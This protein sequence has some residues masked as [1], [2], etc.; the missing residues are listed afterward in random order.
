MDECI[1]SLGEAQIFT[2]LDCNSGYWQVEVD[3]P[4]RD[5]TK[6]TSHFGVYRFKCIPFGLRNT[7]AR[8]Q[9]AVDIILEMVKWQLALL[10][11]G[12]VI[13]YSNSFDEQNA[14]V[15]TVLRML[16]NA[17]IPLGIEKSQF[18]ESS[19]HYDPGS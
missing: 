2:T 18:F 14:H 13:I 15:E 1:D 3:E 4:D 12:D 5:R 11:L 10:Y 16:R 17:A 9:R 8:F 7:R 19:V 6:F